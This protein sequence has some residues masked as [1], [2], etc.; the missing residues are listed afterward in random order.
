MAEKLYYI[1]S[2]WDGNAMLWWR[3]DAKGYTSNIE[4]AGR[5]P[6]ER[7][8]SII[9]NRP[10]VEVAWECEYIDNT[11]E[12]RKTVIGGGKI[13]YDKRIIAKQRP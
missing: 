9:N 7:M 6:A 13:N 10:D 12:I 8:L 3:P 4:E 5:Y 11:P 1:Q 2:G